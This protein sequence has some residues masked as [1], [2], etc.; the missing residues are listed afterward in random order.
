MRT[1]NHGCH[2]FFL[3]V[4][5]EVHF[6]TLRDDGNYYKMVLTLALLNHFSHEISGLKVTDVVALIRELSG[7]WANNLA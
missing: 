4:F 7:Y 1:T 5:K 3:H 2:Q 6:I